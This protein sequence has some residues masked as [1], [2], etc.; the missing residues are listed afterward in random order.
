MALYQRDHERKEF[1]EEMR[2]VLAK[3]SLITGKMRE[4]YKEYPMA[5]PLYVGVDRA[6]NY[7]TFCYFDGD[8]YSGNLEAKVKGDMVKM[9]RSVWKSLN[10]GLNGNLS[11][12]MLLASVRRM[13]REGYNVIPVINSVEVSPGE[14][15]LNPAYK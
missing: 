3:D 14:T 4:F 2:K 8:E 9:Q 5:H 7:S 11:L 1:P 10:C 12:V 13:R 6:D 15:K